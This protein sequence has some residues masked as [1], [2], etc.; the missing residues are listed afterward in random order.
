METK[1]N[2]CLNSQKMEAFGF[3]TSVFDF[4]IFLIFNI[5]IW[6]ELIFKNYLCIYLL[7]E[8]GEGREKERERNITVWLPLMCLQLGTWPATQACALDWES[9]RRPLGSQASTQSTELSKPGLK[10][11]NLFSKYFIPTICRT[12]LSSGDTDYYFTEGS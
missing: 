7:L 9:N 2:E 12:I 10:E 1:Q 3:H 4:E 5:C 11:I 6:N 8:K